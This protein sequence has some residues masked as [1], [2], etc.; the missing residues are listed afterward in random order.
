MS[1]STCRSCGESKPLS[2]FTLRKETGRVR[3]ECKPCR[4]TSSAAARYGLSVGDVLSLAKAQGSRCAICKV[5]AKDIAHDSFKHNPLV[6][7]HDHKTG[8]V[9]G[10]LCPTCNLVL[11]HAKD[12]VN[13]LANAISYLTKGT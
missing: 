4:S 5:H 2:E 6:I 10:L 11:G 9:R 13:L 8:K 12:D 1:H 7:D 3:S